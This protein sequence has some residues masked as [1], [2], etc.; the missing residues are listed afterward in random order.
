MVLDVEAAFSRAQA[1]HGII[2]GWAAEEITRKAYIRYV[3]EAE[4]AQELDLVQHRMVALLNVWS[5]SMDHGAEEYVHFGTTTV[6]IYDTVNV[7]HLRQSVLNGI[8][9]LR[10][11]ES[12]M[13]GIAKENRSTAM[14]GR[15]L[16]QHA[17]PITF[18]KKVSGW[19]ATN[20]RNIERLKNVLEQLEQAAILKGAVGN[21]L[22]LGEKGIELEKDFARELGL[23]EPFVDD[24]HGSRD[25]FAEYSMLMA[26]ISKAF[27]QIGTEIFLLQTT[28]IDEVRE[29]RKT[30]AIGS[31]AMPH[32]QNPQKSEALIFYSRKIPRLAEVVLDDMINFHERDDTSRTNEVLEEIDNEC[33]K[34]FDEADHLINHLQ[35]N[36]EN[37]EKNMY[38]TNGLILSQ[39]VTLALAG[40][41]GN[42]TANEKM[43]GV[44]DYACKHE[45]SLLEAIRIHH[46]IAELLNEQE[47][48]QLFDLKNY[49]GLACRQV[50]EIIK[51]VCTM[52]KTDPDQ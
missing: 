4:L 47:L 27:G 26:L 35:V 2:P 13:I 28:D 34:M 8:M 48:E 40:H 12:V 50:D 24:W 37:M 33:R 49:T 1:I 46:D 19:I 11:I 45:V 43:H 29:V 51:Y 52:R 18:G 22:G 7:L 39:R 15:T 21:Y 5:K 44:V 10:K 25:I 3:P 32:K 6:D 31:S 42:K 23:K 17:L 38:K 20:R 14:I 41:L 36:P 30:T 16:G 9:M